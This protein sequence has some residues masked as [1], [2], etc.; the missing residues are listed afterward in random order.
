MAIEGC[1]VGAVDAEDILRDHTPD[2]AIE[3][4]E[5]LRI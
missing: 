4:R 5:T 3:L 2:D 1:E